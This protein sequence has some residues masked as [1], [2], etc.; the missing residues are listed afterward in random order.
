MHLNL[1]L[2]LVNLSLNLSLNLLRRRV[3]D[4]SMQ[5]IC[6]INLIYMSSCPS[7]NTHAQIPLKFERACNCGV[8]NGTGGGM[9]HGLA[10]PRQS[11]RNGQKHVS[12][13]HSMQRIHAINL[14]K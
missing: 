8:V 14:R 2:N 5:R 9:T 1:N 3:L 4:H 12:G 10:A 13:R 6:D 7:F 11:L